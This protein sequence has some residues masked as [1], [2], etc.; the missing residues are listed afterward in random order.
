M[1]TVKVDIPGFPPFNVMVAVPDGMDS[2][3]YI[4]GLLWS[5]MGDRLFEE[6]AWEFADGI[7]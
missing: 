4:N 5:L 3:G 1:R 2:V 7:S 6:C